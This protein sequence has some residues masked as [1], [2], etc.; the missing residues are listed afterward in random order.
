M[1][2]KRQKLIAEN[3]RLWSLKIR[4]N[5]VCEFSGRSG[6]IKS[7]DAHHIRGRRNMSTRW[8]LNNGVCLEKGIHRFKVH[9]DTLTVA[10]LI[11]SLKK[12]RG[13]AW[14]SELVRKSNTIAKYSIQDLENIK[15]ELT[16]KLK[17]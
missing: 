5:C 4:E 15:K 12:T 10:V 8:D 11:E 6:D 17:I 14:Y 16:N 13:E 2:S 9:M 1:K 7:F 3:D